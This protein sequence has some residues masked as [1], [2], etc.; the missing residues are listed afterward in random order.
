MS[1]VA[2][3][4]KKL[5]VRKQQLEADLS[6]LSREK[7]SDSEVPDPS[8]QA[9][10]S[11][12]EELNISLQNN[13]LAEYARILKA[14]EMIDQGSYGKCSDCDQPISERRLQLFPNA[15]RCLSCQEA[16]EEQAF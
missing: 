13:E 4:K 3:I 15:T 7:V 12:L 14:L 9:L 8:D 16:R 11:T 5:L 2:H 1:N 6:R 10:V